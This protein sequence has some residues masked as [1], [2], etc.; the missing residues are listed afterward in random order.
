MSNEMDMLP[1]RDILDSFLAFVAELN[2]HRVTVGARARAVSPTGQLRAGGPSGAAEEQII[3]AFL[4]EAPVGVT[5]QADQ[6]EDKAPTARPDPEIILERLQQFLENDARN[7]SRKAT[8]MMLAQYREAQYAMVALADDVFLHEIDWY[9]RDVWRGNHLEQRIFQSRLA[10]D[11]IFERMDKLLASGDR[12]LL[13]LASIYLCILS[14]GFRGRHRGPRGEVLVRGYAQRLFEMISG[15]DPLLLG[16][17]ATT[18]RPLVPSAYAHTVTGDSARRGRF[19]L[20][21]PWVAALIVAGWLVLGQAA[22]IWFSLDT[23]NA[24]HEILRVAGGGAQ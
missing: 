22:W 7:F 15:R 3:P 11:R 20:R 14:L 16:D 24:V 19:Q 23:S 13:Q 9:G 5:G 2:H 18:V 12:R 4:L 17:F 21:W 10:G 8:E 6:P 1:R